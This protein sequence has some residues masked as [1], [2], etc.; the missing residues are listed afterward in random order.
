MVIKVL[1]IP[2]AVFLSIL[3]LQRLEG[4]LYPQESREGFSHP[5]RSCQ[6][7]DN[8]HELPR[9]FYPQQWSKDLSSLIIKDF[10]SHQ[11]ST[12]YFPRQQSNTLLSLAIKDLFSSARQQISLHAHT[13]HSY[14]INIDKNTFHCIIHFMQ[15]N[16]VFQLTFCPFQDKIKSYL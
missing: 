11:Q 12:I 16:F 14:I 9:I 8:P 1:G 15:H 7:F 4:S 2:Q 6:S 3:Q 10:E 5:R 13:L